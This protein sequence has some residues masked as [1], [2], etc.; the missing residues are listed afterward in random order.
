MRNELLNFWNFI[1]TIISVAVTIIG[2]IATMVSINQASRAKDYAKKAMILVE[3][4]G[5][6]EA[7]EK[8]EN[9]KAAIDNIHKFLF[10]KSCNLN[11]GKSPFKQIKK[12][13]VQIKSDFNELKFIFPNSQISI[14]DSKAG[15]SLINKILD[16][17]SLREFSNDVLENFETYIDKLQNTIKQI[18][19]ENTDKLS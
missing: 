13:A 15:L 4:D 1:L 9:I 2:I 8:I 19:F 5:F 18:Q 16:A 6:K 10:P 14:L 17:K 3:R 7:L 12:E 11:R